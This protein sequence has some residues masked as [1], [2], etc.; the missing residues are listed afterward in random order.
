MNSSS[1]VKGDVCRFG[2][3]ACFRWAKKVCFV[4]IWKRVKGLSFSSKYKVSG[5]V[6]VMAMVENNVNRRKTWLLWPFF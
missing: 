5:W 1:S 6:H 2:G 4:T 3:T